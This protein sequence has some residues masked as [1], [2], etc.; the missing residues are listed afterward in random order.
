MCML[1]QSFGK[2]R[3]SSYST[4][5]TLLVAH[6]LRQSRT[7]LDGKNRF[8]SMNMPKTA[9]KVHNNFIFNCSYAKNRIKV[10][11]NSVFNCSYAK[12]GIKSNNENCCYLSQDMFDMLTIFCQ[13]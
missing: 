6:L 1:I 3:F 4:G 9:K 13:S 2:K 5:V 12:N 7:T 8:L 11:N 10:H